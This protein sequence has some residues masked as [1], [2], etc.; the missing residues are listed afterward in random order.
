MLKFCLRN[1]SFREE[2]AQFFNFIGDTHC[3]CLMN[4]GF[5][6]FYR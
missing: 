1:K 5:W 6:Y 2:V 4:G 3:R